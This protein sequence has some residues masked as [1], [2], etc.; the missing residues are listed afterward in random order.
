MHISLIECT[1]GCKNVYQYDRQLSLNVLQYVRMYFSI[2][3]CT[4]VCNNA[5]Q[6]DRMYC[7]M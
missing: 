7:W 5:Y 1:A 6:F 3:E 4:A 2:I